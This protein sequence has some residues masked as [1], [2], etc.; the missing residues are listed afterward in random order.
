MC[1]RNIFFEILSRYLKYPSL[2]V[3]TYFDIRESS[4]TTIEAGIDRARP[5]ELKIK[6]IIEKKLNRK[7]EAMKHIDVTRD[8]RTGRKT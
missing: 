4:Q 1:K 5:K 3:I 6:Q 7:E 2:L 8:R